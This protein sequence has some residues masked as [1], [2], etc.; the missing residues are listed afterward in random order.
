M[1]VIIVNVSEGISIHGEYF[2][3]HGLFIL[4]YNYAETVLGE[5]TAGWRCID[6]E[7]MD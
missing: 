7:H 5:C 3:L 6:C 2:V 1:F 4:V